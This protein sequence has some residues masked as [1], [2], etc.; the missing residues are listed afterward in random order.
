MSSRCIL[1]NRSSQK[2]TI[3]NET[4]LAISEQ[5]KTVTEFKIIQQ[6]IKLRRIIEKGD[7]IRRRNNIE[8]VGNKEPV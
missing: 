3:K 2:I 8:R 6:F 7:L 1:E 4:T 5:T